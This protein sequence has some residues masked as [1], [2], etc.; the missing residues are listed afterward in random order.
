MER[1][2]ADWI[3]N[4]TTSFSQLI[5]FRWYGY[6]VTLAPS[7]EAVT[8]A[9]QAAVNSC[10]KQSSQEP[11]NPVTQL[12]ANQT[13]DVLEQLRCLANGREYASPG[14]SLGSVDRLTTWLRS[15]VRP[16][17]KT[18]GTA[19]ANLTTAGITSVLRQMATDRALAAAVIAMHTKPAYGSAYNDIDEASNDLYALYVAGDLVR[20]QDQ[21]ANSAAPASN[22]NSK[23]SLSKNIAR[24][25]LAS[26]GINLAVPNDKTQ[27]ESIDFATGDMVGAALLQNSVKFDDAK[28]TADKTTNKLLNRDKT[29]SGPACTNA[30][31]VVR[32]EFQANNIPN[33]ERWSQLATVLFPASNTP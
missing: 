14:S 1:K 13:S 5:S 33:A 20:A 7:P 25:D 16:N 19:G 15:Q 32:A 4:C 8:A 27:C 23:N 9:N 2:G 24:N 10:K 21:L 29:D 18:S 3:T 26:D 11:R 6:A 30:G 17:P 28:S 22:P 12:K 31:S